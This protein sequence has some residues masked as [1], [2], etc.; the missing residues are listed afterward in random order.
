MLQHGKA[1]RHLRGL[2][3]SGTTVSRGF[4]TRARLVRPRW[5]LVY[6]RELQWN[7]P[8]R[9]RLVCANQIRLAGMQKHGRVASFFV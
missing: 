3:I 4:R 7:A 5:G 2:C 6:V 8:K 1:C 9:R